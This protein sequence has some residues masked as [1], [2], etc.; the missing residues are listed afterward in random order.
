MPVPCSVPS[1]HHPHILYPCSLSS[2]PYFLLLSLSLCSVPIPF[3]TSSLFFSP[4]VR[5]SCS[6]APGFLCHSALLPMFLSVYL[7]CYLSLLLLFLHPIALLPVYLICSLSSCPSVC[8]PTARPCSLFLSPSIPALHPRIFYILPHPAPCSFC[9]LLSLSPFLTP[10]PSPMTDRWLTLSVPQ[11][12]SSL[13]AVSHSQS[14]PSLCLLSALCP[15]FL[16]LCY[17]VILLLSCSSQHLL[18][19]YPSVLLPVTNFFPKLSSPHTSLSLPSIL[20][21]FFSLCFSVLLHPTPF[22]SSLYFLA[23]HL[24]FQSL[25]CIQCPL[26]GNLSVS[27]PF[28]F[29]L[30][31]CPL[32]FVLLP[33]SVLLPVSMSFLPLS[34]T[35]FFQ[36]CPASCLVSSHVIP[37]L[38]SLPL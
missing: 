30:P 10:A 35:L 29:F 18:L 7:S 22:F 21:Y 27:L 9:F 24:S 23:L 15:P 13:F 36:I 28:I 33:H 5:L 8:F 16:S 3:L 12:L 4:S 6:F 14:C 20:S 1:F 17:S 32:Y 37:L 34:P 25:C 19:L 26:P 2:L 31:C 38:S 11:C